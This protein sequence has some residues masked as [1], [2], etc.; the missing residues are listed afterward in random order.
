MIGYLFGGSIIML[1]F[2]V[3][4]VLLIFPICIFMTIYKLCTNKCE[5]AAKWAI[6][7]SAVIILHIIHKIMSI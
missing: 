1:L 7:P 5:S 4:F 3:I 6:Y 2:G